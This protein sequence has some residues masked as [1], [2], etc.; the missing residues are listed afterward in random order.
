MIVG[1]HGTQTSPGRPLRARWTAPW[2]WVEGVWRRIRSWRRIRFTSGGLA[3][4]GGTLA[5]GFAAMNTGNNLLHLL[6]GAMLGIV[7]VSGWLSERA[8]R[9][10]RISRLRP[11]PATVGQ[12]IRID[13]EVANGKRYLPSLAVE[14]FEEGLPEPA[15]VAHVAAGT[16]V[17]VR[18]GHTFVRRGVYPLHTVTLST[19][20][21]FGLFRKERDLA[22]P[23]EIV[24]WPRHD[25]RVPDR[26]AEGDRTPRED[27]SARAQAGSRGEYRS[28]RR[29]RGGDDP[30]DIHWR[31]SA[32]LATP[33]VREY[34]RDAGVARWIC[35]D[36]RGEENDAA[37]RAVEI[38][39]SL[40]ASSVTS[41]RPVGLR[42]SRIVVGVGEGPAQLDRILDA[43]AR[44]EFSPDDP[45][46]TSPHG[47][48]KCIQVTANPP[49][50]VL[51]TGDRIA[52]RDRRP[53]PMA[54]T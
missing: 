16:S 8:I 36:T 15:F 14:I 9:D 23:G 44:V 6:L 33:V 12:V 40:A 31:S 22:I 17:S 25:L 24:V 20:F 43:L 39:A 35:L 13:Y 53:Q 7:A 11:S 5:V 37:E 4:T 10:L 34:E 51:R 26:P 42:T 1:D 38:A 21:P 50:G 49:E 27:G 52:R 2:H 19:S 46:P 41:G 18:S 45:P 54:A 48:A 47:S 32:R 30:R 28:L 3:F 29:Y